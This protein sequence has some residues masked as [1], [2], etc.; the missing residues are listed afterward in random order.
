[1]TSYAEIYRDNAAEW[2][3]RVKAGNHEIVAQGESYGTMT[4]AVRGLNDACT[5][6]AGLV[7]ESGAVSYRLIDPLTDDGLNTPVEEPC[8]E[9]PDCG[10]DPCN[11]P[12]DEPDA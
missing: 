9:E 2:R 7:D 10:D 5:A 11:M 1:M 4:E 8:G 6:F 3:F 12:V